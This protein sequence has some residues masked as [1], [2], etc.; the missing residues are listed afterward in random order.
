MIDI[1]GSMMEGGG[2]ILRMAVAYSTLLGEPVRVRKIRLGRTQPGLKPQHMKTLEA[3][4]KISGAEVKGLA[5]R[6]REITYRPGMPRGGS[7]TFDIG[8]AGSISLLLQCLA[9][10]TAFADS[11]VKLRLIG[12]T[13]VQW[14][15]PVAILDNVIWE[16]YREMGFRGS[17]LV[18]RRG[19]YPKGGGVVETEI[20]PIVKLAGL[21]A[22]RQ[23]QV[24]V[25]GI[26]LCG[27]L[28]RHVA[29]R[30]AKSAC[31]ILSDAGYTSDIEVAELKG[32]K[33]T[34]SPG[35]SISLWARRGYELF[36]G[37]SALGV[38]GKPAE[39]VGSDAAK[40]VVGE[41]DSGCC[42]DMFTADNLILW[43]SIADGS[44]MFTTSVVSKHTLTAIRLAE[45]FTDSEISVS[46]GASGCSVI[47]IEGVGLSA[48][49]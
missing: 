34:F 43:A 5:P 2:Q 38:R 31:K 9:P 24:H 3:A 48:S 37:G 4:S 28:P 15:P 33:S 22:T 44:T 14:S 42:V 25:E 18:Q 36:M 27:R 1:D 16:A 35:S 23:G 46:E 12:G 47:S 10:I 41:L 29:E 21:Q 40:Q 17:L 32:V 20:Q 26:S 6:S 49:R 11:T 45:I 30:Q 7:Y 8:T 39:R 13:D 19:F